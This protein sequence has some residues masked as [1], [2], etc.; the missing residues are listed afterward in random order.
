MKH[1]LII[2]WLTNMQAYINFKNKN[3]NGASAG[4]C[5]ISNFTFIQTEIFG[6]NMKQESNIDGH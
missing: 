5:T 1:S 3:K 2:T 6:G 4:R